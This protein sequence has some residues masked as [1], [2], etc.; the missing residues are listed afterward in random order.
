MGYPQKEP[1]VILV[2]NSAL[3]DVST[4]VESP[5]KAR[6]A[7]LWIIFLREQVKK[8]NIV[9]KYIPSRYNIAVILTAIRSGEVSDFLF[10]T[11][12]EGHIAAGHPLAD[13][14]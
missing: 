5:K 13:E 8:E 2:D 9:L 10:Q 6:Y 7:V 3:I 12:M 4:S 1:T 11:M 14:K